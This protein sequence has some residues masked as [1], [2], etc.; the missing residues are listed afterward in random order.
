MNVHVNG[1]VNYHLSDHGSEY[2]YGHANV[3]RA[4]DVHANGDH[5]NGYVSRYDFN[6]IFLPKERPFVLATYFRKS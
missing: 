3:Y 5:G 1:E 6:Y 2:H 4:Y